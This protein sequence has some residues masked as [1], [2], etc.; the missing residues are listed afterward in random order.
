[1]FHIFSSLLNIGYTVK[2]YM[3]WQI[4]NNWLFGQNKK[5]KTLQHLSLYLSIFK[6]FCFKIP[7]W[8]I[9]NYQHI[10]TE[11]RVEKRCKI[12]THYSI[13]SLPHEYNNLSLRSMLLLLLGH[14]SRVR[15][16]ATPGTAAHQAPPV[17]GILQARTLEW[18]AISFS[19]AGK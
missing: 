18:V 15:L 5:I 8:L 16:C 9:S 11:C 12:R 1:M 3:W 10:I 2:I 19:N 4:F 7:L 17:P 6:F 14:F 13:I